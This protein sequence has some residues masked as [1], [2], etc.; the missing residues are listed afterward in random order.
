MLVKLRDNNMCQY[1]GCP[2][3][4]VHAHHLYSRRHFGTRWNLDNIIL[5]CAGCHFF[6]AHKEYEVFREFIVRR[7][8]EDKYKTLR[9]LAYSTTKVDVE[10]VLMGL[11]LLAKDLRC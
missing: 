5:L 11:K 7:L 4:G 10:L 6:I 1:P 9:V 2:R 8:G 3:S